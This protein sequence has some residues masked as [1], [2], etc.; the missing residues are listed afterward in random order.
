MKKENKTYL[1]INGIAL[2]IIIGLIAFVS[3]KYGKEIADLLKDPKHFAEWM[4]SFGA[5]GILILI[6]FQVLQ[7]IIA[8]IPGEVIQIASGTAFG[9]FFG[10]LYAIIGLLLGA[11]VVFFAT[12]FFGFGFIKALVPEKHLEKYNKLLNDPKFEII[13]FVIFI[14]PGLPKDVLV[15]I[16]GLT[17]IKPLRF[18]L[19][20]LIARSPAI[21][22]SAIIGASLGKENYVAVA[23]IAAI[24][25]VAFIIGIIF[26]EKIIHKASS[27]KK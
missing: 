24:A 1:I 25:I 11:V 15:Y 3:I 21:I 6:G 2:F 4:Q 22:G 16:A 18:F 20:T 7:I 5:F 10:S 26:Q 12:R 19:I 17:P 27:F 13:L 9:V 14:I 8:V 23:I